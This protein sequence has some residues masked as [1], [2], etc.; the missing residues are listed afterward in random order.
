MKIQII[1]LVLATLMVGFVSCS[2]ASENKDEDSKEFNEAGERDANSLKGL[3]YNIP[4]PTEIP[5]MIQATDAAFNEA[6]VHDEKKASQ[7]TTR[8]DK[9]AINLGVYAADIGYL[10]SY[11]KTQEAIDYLAACKTLSDNL[12]VTGTFDNE[13]IKKFEDNV[14]NKDSL[15][16]LVDKTIKESETYLQG[17]NR[18]ELSPLIIAG[19]FIEGLHLSTGLVKTYPKNILPE[20]N[21]NVILTPVM[22]V[23]LDQKASVSELVR[24]L[25]A[26]DDTEIVKAI[27]PDLKALEQTYRD[28]NIDEQIERNRSDLV[29][30]D[31]NL[32]GITTL[33]GKMRKTITD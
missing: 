9:A 17:S 23:I 20:D 22:R 15:T 8:N 32:E 7:Y 33:V 31:K 10:A 29:L 5:Y 12:G 2:P 1:Y 14:S 25:S 13:L 18:R 21:R 3:A 27:L 24:I 11:D 4:P 30:T 6:L 19:S 26:A 16:R 28:M